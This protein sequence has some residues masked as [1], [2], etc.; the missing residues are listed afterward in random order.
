MNVKIDMYCDYA[1]IFEYDLFVCIY[2]HND[3]LLPSALLCPSEVA[4]TTIYS[5]S[6]T[7]P[8]QHKGRTGTGGL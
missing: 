7:T 5:A 8:P 6:A 2:G 3:F 4:A 1:L